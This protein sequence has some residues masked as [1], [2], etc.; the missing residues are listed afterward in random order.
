MLEKAFEYHCL[1]PAALGSVKAEDKAAAVIHQLRLET[2][3]L[4]SLE[5]L[6][7]TQLV[8]CTTDMGVEMALSDMR[9]GAD[10]SCRSF[11]SHS[12]GNTDHVEVRAQL[13]S[14]YRRVLR[15]SA[16]PLITGMA[17]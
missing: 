8:S 17:A 2:T 16:P 12:L 4:V 13:E 9:R 10:G 15:S 7:C 5:D 14:S 1:V 11:L 6:L 3:D